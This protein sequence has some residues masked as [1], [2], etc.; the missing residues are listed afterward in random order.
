M[1]QLLSLGALV[2]IAI[3]IA[4]LNLYVS[5]ITHATKAD[6]EAFD[7]DVSEDIFTW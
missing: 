6:K 2:V 5:K 4:A 3:A 7:E 1:I